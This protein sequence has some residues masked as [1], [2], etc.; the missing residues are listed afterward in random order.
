MR[1]SDTYLMILDEG[2]E[3]GREQEARAAVLVVG[4]VRL[5]QAPDAFL[6]Q[7]AR[8]TDL[9]HLERMI[10]RA[11]TATTWQEVLDTP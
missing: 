4:E 11:V 2:R 8:V 7:L 6:A 10:V 5:G 1:E 9:E 3:E